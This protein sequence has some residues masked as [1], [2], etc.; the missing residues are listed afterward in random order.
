MIPEGWIERPM[1]KGA[2]VKWMRP[3]VPPGG[4]GYVE[5]AQGGLSSGDAIHT[6]GDYIKMRTGGEQFHVAA[7]GNSVLSNPGQPQCEH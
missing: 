7:Q 5:Y 1:N 4:T 6:G 3:G 2:G